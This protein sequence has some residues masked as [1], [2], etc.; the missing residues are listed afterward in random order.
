MRRHVYI[1]VQIFFSLCFGLGLRELRKAR[2]VEGLSVGHVPYATCRHARMITP[3]MGPLE[4]Y[5]SFPN[6]KL[7]KMFKLLDDSMKNGEVSFR[8]IQHLFCLSLSLRMGS[9]RMFESTRQGWFLTRSPKTKKINSHSSYQQYSFM[10]CCKDISFFFFQ[11]TLS[12]PLAK[13]SFISYSNEYCLY[14]NNRQL[15]GCGYRC[16]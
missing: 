15:S 1:I 11:N 14:T 3:R 12:F 10:T 8:V 5:F 4:N 13:V 2:A 6:I 7:T 16:Y 9:I